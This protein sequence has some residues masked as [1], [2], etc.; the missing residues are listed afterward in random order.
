MDRQTEARDE[1]TYKR[2]AS[3]TSL[4]PDR[5]NLSIG[6][7]VKGLASQADVQLVK[8]GACQTEQAFSRDSRDSRDSRTSG[9]ASLYFLTK[10]TSI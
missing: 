9:Q 5:L 6:L 3:F 10:P 8:T 7:Q 1:C 2:L 4:S